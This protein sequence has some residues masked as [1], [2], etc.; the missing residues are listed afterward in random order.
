VELFSAEDI[1]RMAEAG[2]VDLK[3]VSGLALAG[4]RLDHADG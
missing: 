3:T 2:D 1:A 4:I